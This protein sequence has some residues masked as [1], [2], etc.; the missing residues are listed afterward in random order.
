MDSTM[1][2]GSRGGACRAGGGGGEGALGRWSAMISED[3]VGGCLVRSRL[4]ATRCWMQH[5]VVW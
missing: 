4:K 3:P 1:A 2:S 5:G